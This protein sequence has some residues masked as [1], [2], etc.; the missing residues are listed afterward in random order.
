MN[1]P[2][3]LRI[4]RTKKLIEDTLLQLIE[5]KGFEHITV[6]DLTQRAMLNRGTFY[7]HYRDIFDLLE[8]FE[9]ETIQG[10]LQV[11]GSTNPANL[12]GHDSQHEPIPVLMNALNYLNENA[13][14]FKI[15]FKGSPTFTTRLSSLIRTH[16]YEDLPK[17][18]PERSSLVQQD[19]YIA[20]MAAA[21]SGIIQ[22]WFETGMTI[23]PREIA[24]YLTRLLQYSPLQISQQGEED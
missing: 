1:K 22:Y 18:Q 16:M 24:L 3:D 2:T 23:S 19:F 4:L 15:L 5:E 7:L 12:L 10:L 9:T 21:H 17:Q 13:R 14:I 8:K 6:R 11:T 20:Y